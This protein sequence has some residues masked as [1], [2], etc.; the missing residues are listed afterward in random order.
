MMAIDFNV[1]ATP[2]AD[3][4]LSVN[5]TSLTIN[6]GASGTATVTIT[7]SGGFTGSV[8]LT[9]DTAVPTLVPVRIRATFTPAS[10]T[11]TSSLLTLSVSS[12][13]PLGTTNLAIG[14]TGG[15]VTHTTFLLLSVSDP[16][17][18]GATVTPVVFA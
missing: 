17:N 7:R 3:F 10:T 11:G 8:A 16:N 14:G 4:A 6:R 1:N 9:I 12:T 15:G 2:Q 13:A 18:G 5:P